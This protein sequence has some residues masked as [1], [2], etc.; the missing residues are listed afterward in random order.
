MNLEDHLGDILR[1]G[2]LHAGVTLEAAAQASGLSPAALATLEETGTLA[3]RPN[4]AALARLLSLDAAKLERVAGGWLPNPT[5]TDPWRELRLIST[6]QQGYAVN[7]YLVWDEV[8][9]E[10]ALF[11]TG[12]DATPSI[13]LI[14]ENQLALR[15]LFITHSHGDH[16]AGLPQLRERF[17]KARVRS[18][19]AAAPPD[20]RNRANDCLQLGSLR[21]MNRATPGHAADGVSYVIGNWPDDA[22]HIIMVG[23]ALF[24]GSMGKAGGAAAQARQQIREQILSLP[25]ATLICPGHGPLTTVAEEL[26][27][28]P[29]FP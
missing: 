28:N 3:E 15:Y 24:A 25:P 16:V 8:T 5:P 18:S 22:P 14:E 20:Q 7:N 10:A 4:F 29:F 1:K 26:A 27:N 19:A 13:R 11:D 2:R 23:D 21:V 9:R 17:P 6:A 12:F